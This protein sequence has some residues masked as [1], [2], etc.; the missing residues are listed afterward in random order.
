[1]KKFAGIT[2]VSFDQHDIE[3][4]K[5]EDIKTRIATTQNYFFPRLEYLIRGSLLLAQEVYQTN[6]YEMMTIVSRPAN[7][8][9]AISNTE[10]EE[11]YMGISGKKPKGKQLVL[12]NYDG[13]TRALPVTGFLVYRIDLSGNIR[14]VLKNYGFGAINEHNAHYW[15]D[16]QAMFREYFQDI[17]TIFSIAQISYWGAENLFTLIESFDLSNLMN[18]LPSDN[19]L[20]SPAHFFPVSFDRGL[21]TLLLAF[22]ILYPIAE[23]LTK[24]SEGEAH[25]L[26]ASLEKFKAW[27]RLQAVVPEIEDQPKVEVGETRTSELDLPEMDSYKHVRAGLWWQVL[28]RD[29]WTCLSCGRTAKDGITLEVDHI[30]PR[31]KGGK[32]SIENLQTLCKKCNI[33]KSNKDDTDLRVSS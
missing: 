33:G 2:E 22:V 6:P 18:H 12:K 26:G 29:N 4:F 30:L 19:I 17:T 1:M 7:R 31:S 14:V 32:D 20:Y 10:F 8:A 15:Q 24:L 27:W 25:N 23:S 13:K 16:V 28:A 21:N 3:I 5:I 9:D 11:V